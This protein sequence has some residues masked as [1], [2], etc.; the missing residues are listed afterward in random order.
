MPRRI[1]CQIRRIK[2]VAP[3]LES[4]PYVIRNKVG[5]FH[6][7]LLTTKALDQ[8]LLKQ[9]HNVSIVQPGIKGTLVALYKI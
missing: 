6:Y 8:S 9:Q 3:C 2:I 5:D 1:A 4:T 7:A